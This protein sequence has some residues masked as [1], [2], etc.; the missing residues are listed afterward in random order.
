MPANRS[1]TMEWRRCL[2]QVCERGGALE[3]ALAPSYEDNG[4]VGRHLIW[5]VKLLA[6]T[7]TEFVVE[8]PTTLGQPIEIKAGL[9][10]VAILAIG[11]NRWMF[12]T[13]NHGPVNHSINGRRTVSAGERLSFSQKRRRPDFHTPSKRWRAGSFVAVKTRRHSDPSPRSPGR[14]R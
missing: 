7:D 6:V 3:I 2:K 10:L 9:D 11:Q 1:R 14:W 13:R 4:G 12:W 5:R 8:Q